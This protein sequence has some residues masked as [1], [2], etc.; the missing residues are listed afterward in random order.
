MMRYTHSERR[1][2]I[3]DSMKEDKKYK[4]VHHKIYLTYALIEM[5]FGIFGS[6]IAQI[7]QYSIILVRWP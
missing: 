1:L 3:R 6:K 4:I 7:T 5:T 2:E